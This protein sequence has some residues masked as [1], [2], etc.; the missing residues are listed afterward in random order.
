MTKMAVKGFNLF[1]KRGAKEG[2]GS[3]RIVGAV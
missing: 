1:L 2:I 3:A